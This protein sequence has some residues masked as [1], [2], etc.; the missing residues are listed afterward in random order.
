MA[1]KQTILQKYAEVS[2]VTLVGLLLI[3]VGLLIGMQA[4]LSDKQS[5]LNALYAGYE[6]VTYSPG[7]IV[8]T[9]DFS[10]EVTGFDI[11]TEGIPQY[12]EVPD[13]QQYVAVDLTFRNKTSNDAILLPLNDVYLKDETGKKYLV[14]TAP[15]VESGVA[16]RVA[17]GDVISGQAGFLIPRSLDN[18]NFY[19]EPLGG[20]DPVV[21]YNLS[22]R[23]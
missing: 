7:D 6:L 19:F 17:A 11:D 22:L 18:V 13:D 2:H 15:N 10:L 23:R 9:P 3:A 4:R 12:L 1:R 8:E 20:Q 14:T 16:G 21:V 5:Q